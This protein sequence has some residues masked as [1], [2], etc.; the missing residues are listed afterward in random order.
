MT[1]FSGK[2][3]ASQSKC[4]AAFT[5]IQSFAKDSERTVTWSLAFAVHCILSAV[6]EVRGS[7]E[8]ANIARHAFYSY[9][10]AYSAGEFQ[11]MSV[12]RQPSVLCK[13]A[14]TLQ[15]LL[16]WVE[17]HMNGCGNQELLSLWNPYC[18]GAFLS[19]IS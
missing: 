16:L 1:M 6:I 10:S 9:T 7:L 12:P 3:L 14:I 17:A 4:L 18:A 8:L 5:H 2:A 11:G 19:Y 15:E 13:R